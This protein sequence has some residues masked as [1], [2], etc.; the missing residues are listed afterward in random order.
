MKCRMKIRKDC[1]VTSLASVM[2]L[3]VPFSAQAQVTEELERPAVDSLTQR[4]LDLMRQRT[5][6]LAFRSSAADFPMRLE[7]EPLFRYDDQ[8]RGY[9]DGTVWRLG[10]EGRAMA[11]VTSELHPNY[12]GGGPR[13]IYDLLS[14]TETPFTA[15]SADI[16]G[17]SPSTSA[18]LIRSLPKSPIPA[19]TR[20]KRL[21]QMKDLA[22][23]F[24][25]AQDVEGQKINLRLLPR[26]IDRYVPSKQLNSDGAIFLFVSGR[27]PGIVLLIES[28]DDSW[29]YGLGRLSAPST[30]VVRLDE[31][32]VWEQPPAALATNQGYTA[33]NATVKI[34]SEQP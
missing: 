33:T 14:L 30:L 31:T 16:P 17:W 7:R 21:S 23:R 28:S 12:L 13:I 22:A 2:L 19:D 6:D 4:R 26:Q 3:L 8:T 25:A 27:N 9:I 34:P 32:V 29:N 18:V 10:H 1:C 20:E 5:Q 11:I 15:K 24:S